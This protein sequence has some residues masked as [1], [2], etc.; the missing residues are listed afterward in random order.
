MNGSK[1]AVVRKAEGQIKN[2][3]AE[4]GFGFIHTYDMLGDGL[5]RDVYFHFSILDDSQENEFKAGRTVT[6]DT[7]QKPEGWEAETVELTPGGGQ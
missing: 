3:N 4:R 6:F 1:K 7:Y 5:W 2:V